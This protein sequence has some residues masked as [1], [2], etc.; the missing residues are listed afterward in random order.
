MKLAFV[1]L[2]YQ[3]MEVTEK[4]L[5]MLRGLDSYNKAV[6]VIVDNASSNGSGKVLKEKYS[7]I[8]NIDVIINASNEG[9]AKGNNLGY[10]YAKNTLHANVIVVMNSDV[11]IED[12]AFI[13]KA[14]G[15]FEKETIDV[16]APDIYALKGFYQN[17][18]SQ[19]ALTYQE[20]LRW[21]YKVC[22]LQAGVKLPLLG[23]LVAKI[24][25]NKHDRNDRIK[26]QKNEEL[27]KKQYDVVPHGACVIFGNK[28]VE[29]V[30]FAFV[31]FTYM[32]CEEYLLA[33]YISKYSFKTVFM[34]DIKVTHEA[35]ASRK[36]DYSRL[37]AQMK[38]F[39]KNEK[40]SIAQLMKMMKGENEL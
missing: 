37:T 7:P 20:V 11:F 10:A 26:A 34:P 19:R 33:Y 1:I 12:A 40:H 32:Y 17:P 3:N 38:A 22:L 15:A 6:V 5:S 29:N 4:C 35:G 13:N 27:R 14:V 39:Y 30:P 36:I 24:L 25:Q 18:I 23:D 9:F 31:P 21:Y 28:W 16:I 2:H 8:P